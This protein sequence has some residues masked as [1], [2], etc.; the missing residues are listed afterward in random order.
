MMESTR[1]RLM[2][3]VFAV[4]T[5]FSVVV[6][7]LNSA[8]S[9]SPSP[10]LKPPAPGPVYLSRADHAALSS[11]ADALKHKHFSDARKH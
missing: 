5:V 10:R 7:A 4:L 6:F 2:K 1:K 11:I 8:A 9:A 3:L